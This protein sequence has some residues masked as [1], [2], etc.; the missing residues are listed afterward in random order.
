MHNN[1]WNENDAFKSLTLIYFH[2]ICN[3]PKIQKKAV[4]QLFSMIKY[5]FPDANKQATKCSII[6]NI[7]VK[8][9]GWIKTYLLWMKT[10]LP[11]E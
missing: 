3:I 9:W 7:N 2:G 10:Y 5:N 8:V 11:Q 4:Q 6:L 1:K